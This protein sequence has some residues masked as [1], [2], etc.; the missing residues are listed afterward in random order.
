MKHS[1][2]LIYV[3]FRE[4]GKYFKYANIDVNVY[5]GKLFESKTAN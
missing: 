2:E 5:L 1:I 3:F 4:I